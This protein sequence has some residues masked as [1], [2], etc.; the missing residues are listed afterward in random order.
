MRCNMWKK[1]NTGETTYYETIKL[2]KN[3]N[4]V[5]IVKLKKLVRLLNLAGRTLDLA[6]AVEFFGIHERVSWFTMRE[7]SLLQTY[8]PFVGSLEM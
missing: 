4:Q 6:L 7:P 2:L 5:K 3:W 8:S 1:R